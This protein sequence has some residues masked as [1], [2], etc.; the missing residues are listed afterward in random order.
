[1]TAVSMKDPHDYQMIELF[2]K[3]GDRILSHIDGASI[4]EKVE[5]LA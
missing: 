4:E 3:V 1:M 5:K 2:R